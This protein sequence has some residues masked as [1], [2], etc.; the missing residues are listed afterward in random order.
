MAISGSAEI[1]G[2][3]ELLRA[4]KDLGGDKI[5]KKEFR[6]ALRAAAKPIQRQAVANAPVHDGPYPE[7]RE[8]RFPG[9]LKSEIKVRAA[10]R[11]RKNAAAI[12][13]SSSGQKSAYQG[14]AY[15]GAFNEY[16]TSRM[17]GK[18]FMRPA[19]DSQ[20][21]TAIN[22]AASVMRIALLRAGK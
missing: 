7:G 13:V 9:K 2:M 4:L 3:P 16:G 6:K 20:K 14:D 12:L 15:Y 17:K 21:E 11:S 22:E 1:H 18:P 8:N 10:K 19:F 5:A